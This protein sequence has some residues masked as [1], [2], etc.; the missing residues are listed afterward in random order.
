MEKKNVLLLDVVGA[1]TEFLISRIFGFEDF[2][3]MKS[4]FRNY[5]LLHIFTELVTTFSNMT[6]SK[7]ASSAAN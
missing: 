7:D 3:A 6:S 2:K 4:D 5:F 1:K